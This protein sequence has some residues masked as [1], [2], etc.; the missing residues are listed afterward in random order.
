MK[1]QRAQTLWKVSGLQKHVHAIACRHFVHIV[2]SY[3][4]GA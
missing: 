3:V 4:C 2:P 1:Q